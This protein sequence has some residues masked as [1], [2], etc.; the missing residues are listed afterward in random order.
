MIAY[1]RVAFILQALSPAARGVAVA[2][3]LVDTD[4]EW[5]EEAVVETLP[6]VLAVPLDDGLIV[7]VMEGVG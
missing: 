7:S 2:L 1:K 4:G 5:E 3:V 6:V